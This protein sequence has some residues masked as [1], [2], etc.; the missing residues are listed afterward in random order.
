MRLFHPVRL[1]IFE[2]TTQPTHKILQFSFLAAQCWE[3]ASLPKLRNQLDVDVVG[4]F[5]IPA[6]GQEG[7][8]DK[9]GNYGRD[10]NCYFK[11]EVPNGKKVKIIFREFNIGVGVDYGITTLNPAYKLDKA[12][13]EFYNSSYLSL[14][15]IS[16]VL[17]LSQLCKF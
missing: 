10:L 9:I 12:T 11:I 14:F 5:T 2:I 3:T 13:G 16:R 8:I 15:F 4:S 17:L 7:T 1:F 6:S